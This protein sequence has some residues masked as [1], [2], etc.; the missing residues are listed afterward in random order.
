M[1]KNI[2]EL[3][4][5]CFFS[6]F[7]TILFFCFR[8]VFCFALLCTAFFYS[9]SYLIFRYFT[10]NCIFS[11]FNWALNLGNHERCVS[12][13]VRYE[14]NKIKKKR[15]QHTTAKYWK[16]NRTWHILI[17]TLQCW[18]SKWYCSTVVSIFFL[19]LF[20]V[21]LLHS[22]LCLANNTNDFL[23]KAQNVINFEC[24]TI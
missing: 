6:L 7:L 22:S 15:Q 4:L 3:L 18:S 24:I 12:L 5:P 13:T 23:L 21:F 17:N 9:Y 20:C 2:R 10:S 1:D 16:L 11:S 19:L 14:T 8:S